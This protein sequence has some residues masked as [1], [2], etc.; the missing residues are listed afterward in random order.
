[1]RIEHLQYLLEVD[2]YHSISVAAQ[3]LFL[4]QTTLSSIV[5]SVEKEL[6]FPIF[7]RTH[8]GVQA[9]K[10]GEEA[11][12][13]IRDISYRFTEIRQLSADQAIFNQSVSIILS[14]TINSVLAL[15]IN[16]AFMKEIKYGNLEF[17][18]VSGEK[19]GTALIKNDANIGMTYF[20]R[21]GYTEY[22]EIASRY[23]LCVERV[24]PDHL[25]LLVSRDHP[26]AARS[27]ISC[28]EL[29]NLNIAMISHFTS[30]VSSL[31]YAK[32]FG[33]NNHY[34]L[35]QNITLIKQAILSRNM[36]AIL[37]GLSIQYS[38][39]AGNDRMKAILLTGTQGEN[40]MDVCL[41]HRKDYDLRYP[42]KLALQCIK[43]YL[44]TLP[45]PPFSPE[46]AH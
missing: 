5:R 36:V 7:Y 41:I 44:S 23:Q 25:Y 19:V 8:H 32:G 39:C 35:F 20:T 12:A 42:E 16:E 43:S 1:M 14:N 13:L 38:K 24:F 22:C 11:L 33:P 40:R 6:G 15:P 21:E 3:N 29:E 18:T 30:C 4:G 45:S 31:A 9:T 10:D 28:R 37:S 46:A 17:R 34:I 2:K 27:S 26:L